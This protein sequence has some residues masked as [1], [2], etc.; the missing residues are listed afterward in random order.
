[1][2]SEK[3]IDKGLYDH[4]VPQSVFAG[5]YELIAHPA[6][7]FDSE[8]EPGAFV[9]VTTAA[10]GMRPV[11]V[12]VKPG[13]GRT[14]AISN[15]ASI[16]G[17]DY[18][19][20]ILDWL[21]DGLLLSFDKQKSLAVMAVSRL[22]APTTAKLRRG[23]KIITVKF[24]ACNHEVEAAAALTDPFP[25]LAA[26][27]AGTYRMGRVRVGPFT[28]VIENA[29]DSCRVKTDRNGTGWRS[30][31][32]AHYG[33]L[34]GTLGNDGDQVD[35]F[36]GTSL[37]S[38]TVYVIN[39]GFGRFDEH[40]LML[41]FASETAARSAYSASY[42]PKWQGLKSVVPASFDQIQWW[43]KNGDMRRP[44]T[45]ADL[46]QTGSVKKMN[47][48]RV[49]WDSAAN[50]IGIDFPRLLYAIRLDDAQDGLMLESLDAAELDL[51]FGASDSIAFDGI[52]STKMALDRKI[53]AL[54]R[55]MEAAAGADV[56]PTGY[57]VS[58]PKVRRIIGPTA[59]VNVDV[60]FTLADGQ[61]VTIAFHN[62]D[63]TPARLMPGD[64]LIS[65]KWL[66]NKRDVTILVAP[67]RG[68]E[69]N[70]REVARRIAKLAE[71]NH[72][73]FVKGAASKAERDAAIA[74]LEQTNTDLDITLS[75]LD[76]D[77][78]IAT[79][80][81]ADL[82]ADPPTK[83]AAE[84][85]AEAKDKAGGKAIAETVA[86]TVRGTLTPWKRTPNILG[87]WETANLNI[88]GQIIRLNVSGGGVVQVN[89]DPFTKM[90]RVMHTS[91]APLLESVMYALDDKEIDGDAALQ[92]LGLA[93][94]TAVGDEN[95]YMEKDYRKFYAKIYRTE[96]FA[97][98]P[99][100]FT[101]E[102]FQRPAAAAAEE[103]SAPEESAAPVVPE[104]PAAREDGFPYDPMDMD[105]AVAYAAETSALI[106][107]GD[108]EGAFTRFFAD[109]NRASAVDTYDKFLAALP[110]TADIGA[111]AIAQIK[112]EIARLD[113][114]PE[115][116]KTVIELESTD[117]AIN[118]QIAKHPKADAAGFTAAAAAVDRAA[119]RAAV[120]AVF[121][122]QQ[123][124]A[125]P[126]PAD[127]RS[128]DPS[129]TPNEA[130]QEASASVP[131]D[132]PPAA[133]A[134]EVDADAAAQSKFTPFDKSAI[135]MP[136][137]VQLGMKTSFIGSAGRP[138]P[139]MF[140]GGWSNGGMLD[141]M[142]RPDFIAKAV[143]KYFGDG[144]GGFTADVRQVPADAIEQIMDRAKKARNLLTPTAVYDG[145]GYKSVILT[146]T[147]SDLAV[148]V[149]LRF[150]SYFA[151]MY[152]GA[153]YLATDAEA[154]VLV[155]KFGVNVGV[156][157]PIRPGK[158]GSKLSRALRA[159]SATPAPPELT[160]VQ[161]VD[162]AYLF[163]DATEAFKVRLAQSVDSDSYSMF[164]TAK[165]MDVAALAN[166][167]TISWGVK[168]TLDAVDGEPADPDLTA[169][170]NREE[171]AEAGHVFDPAVE[172]EEGSDDEAPS[173]MPEDQAGIFDAA[174]DVSWNAV[175]RKG[176]DVVGRID[177][178]DDGK[179]LVYVGASGSQRVKFADG[180]AAYFGRDA[181]DMI[182]ALF[183]VPQ[184]AA[185]AVVVEPNAVDDVPPADAAPA[186]EPIADVPPDDV[187]PPPAADAPALADPAVD[188]E[189]AAPSERDTDLAFLNAVAAGTEDFNASDL[190]DRLEAAYTRHPGDAEIEAAMI[191]A[192]NAFEADAVAGARAALA[193]A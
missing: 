118:E 81:L 149:D 115:A 165:E 26:A 190:A 65:W 27:E 55:V 111:F 61:T 100:D 76:R 145:G 16:F 110:Q 93:T 8:S 117:F 33:Y 173:A 192:A 176:G 73:A 51:A 43:L 141:V 17:K 135:K 160:P 95:I 177:L 67:E 1:M 186:A 116:L 53:A 101:N 156:I 104:A 184:Q 45:A 46:P 140:P 97:V 91:V 87:D 23:G 10:M 89:G 187:V 139:V 84:A 180:S 70:V 122:P 158:T 102:T 75:K 193:G 159:A 109:P 7:I 38:P 6:M 88:D 59:T 99:H 155:K 123:V 174:G 47:I 171:D 71:K 136:T 178:G 124:G 92:A 56:K 163:A 168:S 11:M 35:C 4:H 167:A 152:P 32:A 114:S 60:I 12:V 90:D 147:S 20:K 18:P 146:D 120:A 79:I 39:Q 5:L 154:A 162:A 106:N 130:R 169:S 153:D 9:V 72:A 172:G 175:I 94:I 108:L 166:G 128:E 133:I 14:V 181:T 36:V 41:G 121:R 138:S 15:I 134:P 58:D 113:P 189:P 143:D 52:V 2:I 125:D 50:P 54:M 63:S 164:A 150:F 13:V 21:R 64:E 19:K 103:T 78:E 42:D 127:V 129:L 137:A 112:A 48:T 30:R 188:A 157:M 66:L 161:R 183:S 182:N 74:A 96:D 98:G 44:L 24:D 57:T 68:A 170:M 34:D 85:P 22:Q 148:E 28:V 185:D 86:K 179:G 37:G 80:E 31:M 49:A 105:A 151:K 62:P 69:V 191:A 40:K 29:R 107:A 126:T 132:E 83:A 25:S 144:A 3:I 131:A 77:I 82:Q 142:Q 119:V